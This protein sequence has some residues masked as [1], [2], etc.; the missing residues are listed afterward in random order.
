[1]CFTHAFYPFVEGGLRTICGCC[2]AVVTACGM[3][4]CS[5]IGM[6]L[7]VCWGAAQVS[8]LHLLVLAIPLYVPHYIT[9]AALDAVVPAWAVVSCTLTTTFAWAFVGADLLVCCVL[10]AVTPKGV[11]VQR[12]RTTLAAHAAYGFLNCKTYSLL[13]LLLARGHPVNVTVWALDAALGV[14][15]HVAAATSRVLLTWGTIFYHQH[16]LAHLPTVRT[17]CCTRGL[18]H[19]Y[20]RGTECVGKSGNRASVSIFPYTPLLLAVAIRR[21]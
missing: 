11:T 9:M 3:T 10:C 18:S 4:R 8:F 16:R 17:R 15:T 6:I 20:V 1:M 7:L 12:D 21:M 19:Q 14:S 2:H 13:V 5:S